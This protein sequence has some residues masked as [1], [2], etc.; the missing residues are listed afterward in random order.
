MEVQEIF[1]TASECYEENGSFELSQSELD[2]LLNRINDLNQHDTLESIQV[3]EAQGIMTI[4]L[5]AGK[6]WCITSLK[7]SS[8]MRK[9]FKKICFEFCSNEEG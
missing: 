6:E 3:R 7:L 9:I 8:E 1:L 4:L 5:Y 2:F